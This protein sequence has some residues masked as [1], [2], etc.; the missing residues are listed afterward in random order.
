MEPPII[1]STLQPKV[2]DPFASI[3]KR[4]LFAPD[5]MRSKGFTVRLEDFDQPSGWKEVGVVSADYL[6]V[7][8]TQVRDMLHEIADRTGLA[9][10]HDKTFFDGKRFAY[11][12]VAREERTVDVKV[13]DAVALGLMA[14]NSYDG[15]ERLSVSAYVHRLA[16]KNGMISASLFRRVAIKHE[17]RNEGWEDDVLRV[18]S[19]LRHAELGLTRFAEAARA[20][21]GTKA[22]PARLRDLRQGALSKLPITL[23]G[24]TIDRMLIEEEHTLWGLLNAATNLTWHGERVS[25]SD[26][27]H[28]E[29]AVSGLI[30]YALGTERR[31]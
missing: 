23:W 3:E 17:R 15:S 25:A 8:N 7:P 2:I 4:S 26:F 30:D 21:S 1:S 27:T 14:S 5:G 13:G 16:C 18:L 9:F 6:L 31:N 29:V 11:G 22:S 24:K 28:N 10:S 12:L 20:L 19:A